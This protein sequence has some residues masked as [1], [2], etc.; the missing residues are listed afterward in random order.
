MPTRTQVSR[1]HD[2]PPGSTAPTLTVTS[3]ASDTSS[4]AP[5][6]DDHGEVS[7]VAAE[8]VAGAAP[9]V[10]VAAVALVSVAGVVVVVA[11]GGAAP[12]FGRARALT[13]RTLTDAVAIG[14][15]TAPATRW[16]GCLRAP[17]ACRHPRSP[18]PSG[19]RRRLPRRAGG[20]GRG[21]SPPLRA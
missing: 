7:A 1:S 14:A 13:A 6:S 16:P 19:H 21:P 12:A 17:P 9:V 2:R 11:D 20:A 18:L 5:T 10:A 4:V 3:G 8:I 15:S